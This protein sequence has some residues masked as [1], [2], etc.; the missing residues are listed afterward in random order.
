MLIVIRP[1]SL[2]LAQKILPEARLI[3]EIVKGK[4]E[5]ELQ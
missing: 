5:V 3:G 2:A 1:S 4:A